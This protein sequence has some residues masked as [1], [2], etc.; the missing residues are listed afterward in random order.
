MI[1]TPFAGILTLLAVFLLACNG[2]P[3]SN[4]F[5]IPAN[6]EGTLRIVFS[7]K[8]GITPKV[9]NGRRI[10]E[11]PNNGL[12]VLSEDAD[13]IGGKDDE[14]FLIDDNGNKTKIA[15]LAKFSDK[16]ANVPAV[17]YEGAGV[18]SSNLRTNGSEVTP[19]T[20]NAEYVDFNFYNKATTEILHSLSSPGLDS[21]TNAVVNKCRTGR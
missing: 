15:N 7:E 9:E 18:S 21:L 20:G 5:L 3:T 11:F 14:F 2:K 19:V 13:M 16:V 10:L 1:R 12:L 17:V 6:Y 8:C 4:T